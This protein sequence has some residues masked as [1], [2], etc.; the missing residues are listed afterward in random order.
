MIRTC[1]LSI[2]AAASKDAE[3]PLQKIAVLRPERL[4]DE[5]EIEAVQ[6]EIVSFCER[7]KTLFALLDPPPAPPRGACEIQI[8]LQRVNEQVG[9]GR[10]TPAFSLG[11]L[12]SS[13]VVLGFAFGD[14]FFDIFD[15]DV[16]GIGQQCASA[17]KLEA[18]GKQHIGASAVLLPVSFRL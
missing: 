6:H 2:P 9:F 13:S 1:S 8:L 7:K 17:F 11:S 18:T 3:K 12:D 10:L 4:R 14:V 15:G 16:D 5:R